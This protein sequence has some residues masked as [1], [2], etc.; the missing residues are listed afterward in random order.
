MPRRV[1]GAPAA[2]KDCVGRVLSP[3]AAD[4]RELAPALVQDAYGNGAVERV[5]V[6]ADTVLLLARRGELE[7]RQVA[8]AHRYR[9]A[10]ERVSATGRS[11]LFVDRVD[12]GT[13]LAIPASKAAAAADI[14]HAREVLGKFA[15][16]VDAVVV[17]GLT[18]D[19][20]ASRLPGGVSRGTK[21]T[22]SV[23]FRM[24]LS[25]LA[26]AWLPVRAA[27]VSSHAE[28][29]RPEGVTGEAVEAGRS[30]HCTARAVYR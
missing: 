4:R 30:A 3:T 2:R 8:A 5:T 14:R 16:I 6:V 20:V 24:A 18:L 13:H 17:E 1:K 7:P 28:G 9:T 15:W 29:Y 21:S 23:L 12:G 19:A 11:A 27:I 10:V 22:A 25:H 26:D